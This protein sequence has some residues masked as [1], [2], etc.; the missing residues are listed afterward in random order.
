[1]VV[2]ALKATWR[3]VGV[4]GLVL[5]T[6]SLFVVGEALEYLEKKAIF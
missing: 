1:V 5:V 6:G 2:E 3:R 4:D